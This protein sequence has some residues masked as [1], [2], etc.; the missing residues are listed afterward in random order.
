[1]S[2][3]QNPDRR[4]LLRQALEAIEGLKTKLRSQEEPIAIIGAGCRFPGGARNLDAYWQLL[5]EGRDA[6]QKIPTSRWQSFGNQAAS[7]DWCAGLIEGLDEFDASFF[8]IS[9]REAA[10]MDPQQ[11]LLL[12]VVWQALEHAAQPPA[13]LVGSRTGVF[14][15]ITGHDYADL[16]REAGGAMDVYAATGNAN[17]AAAGRISFTLG[18]Q[19]PSVAIDTAC[20]S[21]LVAIHLACQSLRNKESDLAV[22]GGVN[23]VL[24]AAAFECFYSWGM[25]AADGRCK[26]FDSRAD[27]FVRGEGCGIVVL[28]RLSDAL[29]QKDRILA[30][31]RGSAVNQDGRSS[32][33]T[34]PNGPAQE[35]VIRQALAA[36]R[37]NP[38]DIDYVEAHGTGTALGDPIESYAIGSVLGVGRQADQKLIVGS[39]KSNIG[40]LESAAGVA[41]L[42]KTILAMRHQTIPA[43]LHFRELN[44][45]VDW[46]GTQVQIPVEQHPWPRGPRK[47]LAGVSG[48]G[49]SGTNAHLVIEEAPEPPPRGLAIDRPLHVF[50][51]SAQTSEALESLLASYRS[52]RSNEPFAD[53]CFTAN[54]GRNHFERRIAVTATC[55]EELQK[56]LP[57]DPSTFTTVPR[58]TPRT[59]FLFSG[60][61]SQYPAMGRDLF[62][63][64]P[65]FRNAL[66][67]CDAIIKPYLEHSLLDLL[68][69]ESGSRNPSLLDRTDY[70]QPVLF[71]L[72]WA[73]AAMW[74]S[75][76]VEPQ[77]VLGHSVGEYAAATFA[78]F[79]TLEDGLRLIAERGRLMQSLG[80]GWGM[81]AVRCQQEAIAP[82]LAPELSLAAVNG[83]ENLTLAGR[84][85]HLDRAEEQLRELGVTVKRLA[86]SHG[87]HSAQ[88]EPI[89]H[90]FASLA[91]N[92]PC[93][94]PRLPLISSVTGKPLDRRT[95]A[96]PAYWR[97]QVL[98]PVQF[99][100][101]MQTLGEL[102]SN[103]YLEVGPGAALIGL[104]RNCVPPLGQ[105]WLASLRAGTPAWEQLTNSVTKIYLR[106]GAI[107]WTGF[108]QPY[109][110]RKISLPTYPF[111]RQRHWIPAT[112]SATPQRRTI[113]VASKGH[114]FLQERREDQQ[115][116]GRVTWS[117]QIDLERFPYLSDHCVQN[118]PLVPATV[119]L[120]I[121]TAVGHEVF[122][123]RPVS[124]LDATFARPLF[125][126]AMTSYELRIEY[127][128]ASSGPTGVVKI[129][130]RSATA[131]EW[132][133]C[134]TSRIATLPDRLAEKSFLP[135]P[136]Q[137]AA[138][139]PLAAEEFYARSTTQ[140]NAWG[141]TFRGLERIW[142]DGQTAWSEG[143]VP[144]P[145]VSDLPAYLAH[146]A[147]A[148][149]CGHTLVALANFCE[150]AAGRGGAFV[151]ES[152]G[153]VTLFA[154]LR[155]RR[156]WTRARIRPTE[157]PDVLLGD[158]AV[159]DEEGNCLSYLE[160][161]RLRF[162]PAADPEHDPRNWHYQVAWRE[163]PALS[164]GKPPDAW[165]I[166]TG[167]DGFG[168][169]LAR[170]M[171]LANTPCLVEELGFSHSEF[172]WVQRLAALC[173]E[174]PGRTIGI[175]NCLGLDGGTPNDHSTE[176]AVERIVRAGGLVDS[177]RSL[178]A[179]SPAS[180]K[181]WIV[182]QGGQAPLPHEG[183]ESP[184]QS[185]LWGMGRVFAAEHPELWGGLVDLCPHSTSEQNADAL[186]R[187]LR[188][189]PT[190]DQVALRQDSVF[191]ARLERIVPPNPREIGFRKDA[192]YLITGGLGALGLEVARWMAQM[193]ARRLVLLSRTPI[194]PRSEWI[195]LNPGNATAKVIASLREI[196]SLGATVFPVALDVADTPALAAWFAQWNRE[197]QPA[198]RGVIHAA[199]TLTEAAIEDM[200]D[201][202][203]SATLRPKFA[204]R[205]L[206]RLADPAG[207][208]FFVMFSSGSATLGAPRLGAYAA[209]NA[210]LDGLASQLAAADQ[211]VTSIAWGL[212]Q[213]GR[214][215][216][217]QEGEASSLSRRGAIAIS[218]EAG[219][220]ALGLLL[221]SG[222]P[223]AVL[224]LNWT[225]MAQRFPAMA[226][227]PFLSAVLASGIQAPHGQSERSRAKL[228]A[229]PQ[230]AR[231]DR[232][233]R[234]IQEALAAIL[235]MPV[236]RLDPQ[237]PLSRFGLDSLTAIELRN[238]ILEETGVTLQMVRFLQ[239]PS[240]ADLA[241]EI[242]ER[243]DIEQASAVE[244]MLPG[245]RPDKQTQF[246]HLGVE[247]IDAA[248]AALDGSVSSAQADTLEAKQSA[249][250]ETFSRL[251]AFPLTRGQRALWFLYKLEPESTAYNTALGFRLLGAI[252]DKALETVLGKLVERH[253]ILRTRIFEIGDE[254]YQWAH[255][256][257]SIRLPVVDLASCPSTIDAEVAAEYARP[258]DLALSPF[259]AKLF[260][261]G[262]EEA[263]LVLVVHHIAFDAWSAE[264]LFDE[265]QRLYRA[266]VGLDSTPLAPLTATYEE[267]VKTEQ[268]LLAS[269]EGR[270]LRQFWQDTI[271]VDV[272]PLW[273]DDRRHAN[274]E[275]DFGSL[276]YSYDRALTAQL[277]EFAANH[278]AT[279]FHVMLAALQALLHHHSGRNAVLVGTPVTGR[280][281]SRWHPVT[282]YFVNLLP[283]VTMVDP[284]L[285][286]V[287]LLRRTRSSVLAA[288]EHQ[289]YPFSLIIEH[290]RQ[291]RGEEASRL[292]QVM[293]NLVVGSGISKLG[294]LAE[295]LDHSGTIRL[296]EAVVQG[297]PIL[298][299]QGQFPLVIEM[300][301]S[302]VTIQGMMKWSPQVF[303]SGAA[304]RLALEYKQLLQQIVE[305]PETPLRD[306]LE[307]I[308]TG[309]SRDEMIL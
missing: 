192:A 224:P 11:R 33:L 166:L 287:D 309:G 305:H 295:G 238:R 261:L 78:G 151:G 36:G 30:V 142:F 284:G 267:W 51:A 234:Q 132:T 101:A 148:D 65:V 173:V 61:G 99:M 84:L 263:V 283:I 227:S 285:C 296:G 115:V 90:R 183:V 246:L 207:L 50:T 74:R 4:H 19:G 210:F 170:R 297:F 72:E 117:T 230:E 118:I 73:L 39:V 80:G 165:L 124:V 291:Q 213:E 9:A 174:Q 59:A 308:V 20:S 86:V 276:A 44:P 108:D 137:F 163:L 245:H 185:A 41:G 112:K 92:T 175:V 71:S 177:L 162:L 259:R 113:S 275:G 111:E 164:S 107:D 57:L 106:G 136:A 202:V 93:Q 103:V 278:G 125:L 288:F 191:A 130:A 301:A 26:T 55:F 298:Q 252:D 232:L 277:R 2:E 97:Q 282:G 211:R 237:A 260:R 236:D 199:G 143:A 144:S 133:L 270:K 75:W 206:Y 157:Q 250:A 303:D 54:A 29:A 231:A 203:L 6:V 306:L 247:E 212:W 223:T 116:P 197:C 167:S 189:S 209:A 220:Q 66:E 31:I 233:V 255:R 196:E 62:E 228:L 24:T 294:Q 188:L 273:R 156:F 17:N 134:A 110:R 149:A 299:Q 269:T 280:Q 153:R 60:Q 274:P 272:L 63:T 12:E 10:S 200:D 102:G 76:G 307:R 171:E 279:L 98:Q 208:D 5:L 150:F 268:D 249:L 28:K 214:M 104:G 182:T 16:L 193:G 14:I 15:G 194:P 100:Q 226:S 300:V 242:L 96:D 168:R 45:N 302:T 79:W 105:L 239:E 121:A 178:A 85:D 158:V 248:I 22:A 257:D 198:I 7:P 135:T 37:V 225:E 181:V 94:V 187:F 32:G 258:F 244:Q 38:A 129:F 3:D 172:N 18:L 190:E 139:Q 240:I 265:L 70:T 201:S 145:I 35:A 179:V 47:R 289:A 229:I 81:L 286:F 186:S 222:G 304:S 176:A 127:E 69:G 23:T 131:S 49:F 184:E 141:V 48:F 140:G 52:L 271:N 235:G 128:A 264:I 120:E 25:M 21:S 46:A 40:H 27:G 256:E 56:A 241:A 138:W 147:V 262:P 290:A 67:A 114:P 119:Y 254:P 95:M 180:A 43:N 266:E 216:N 205:E 169:E 68:Y 160:G 1:M 34:V 42:I 64:Q 161:A 53:L 82:F 281:D 159:F 83:P 152:I 126:Q 88:M 195:S 293:F 218:R 109:Q 204:A 58:E 221:Q 215:G 77:V 251:G 154:P 146:P 8:R 243:F 217:S 253:P 13:G 219:L 292:V 89:A 87:F 91:A 155:N 123:A 122:E